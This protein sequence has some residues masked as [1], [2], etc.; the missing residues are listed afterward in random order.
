MKT[1]EEKLNVS[2]LH[3]YGFFRIDCRSDGQLKRS[4]KKSSSA[5]SPVQMKS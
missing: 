1:E 2:H 4:Y 3:G 5:I